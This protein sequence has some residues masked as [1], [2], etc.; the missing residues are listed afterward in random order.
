MRMVKGRAAKLQKGG[1]RKMILAANGIA[2]KF[3]LGL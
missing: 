3:F 2:T 1:T